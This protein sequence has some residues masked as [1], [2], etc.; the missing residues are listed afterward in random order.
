MLKSL[1]RLAG[2]ALIAAC[3][4]LTVAAADLRS[5]APQRHGFSPERLQRIDLYMNEA[6]ADGTMVGGLGM[7][8]RGNRMVYQRTW[9]MSDRETATPMSEDAIFRIYSMSKPITAVALMMLYEEGRFSLNDPVADYLPEFSELRV[10]LSTAGS[11][12]GVISDGTLSLGSG[13]DDSEL[14]GQ[15]REPARPP[16]VRDLLLH[17]AGMTYGIFGETEVDAL[18][19]ENALFEHRDLASFTR[20]LG[21]LPLQ[22]DPGSRW[23]YSVSVDVQGRL[24]EVLSGM[25]FGEFLEKR[26]FIPLGMV[27]TAFRVPKEK[28]SRL[29]TLYSPKGTVAGSN[30]VW[31]L[32]DS[33]ELVPADIEATRSFQEDELFE[34]GG[35]GLVSTAADYMRFCLMVLNGG[36]LNG[37]RLLSPRTVDLMTTNH[38]GDLRVG[39]QPGLGF[40][41]GF[42]VVL[43]PGLMGELGSTGE[44]NW[45]GAAGTRFWIDREEEVVGVFMVQSIPHRTPLGRRFKTLTYQA[46]VD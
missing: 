3:L 17:T 9:G 5:G 10:A 21:A 35:G 38:L 6:V 27:D 44:V 26:I 11:E 2:W 29:A 24:V 16:T 45:G 46:L 7:I 31:Q 13:A 40:G 41:L 34:S 15:T 22:Y 4:S 39:N 19:R 32:S 30:V 12:T 36:E 37:V 33:R 23:H 8:A 42:A 20:T 43:D 25:R 14:R 18:Y 28:R 1:F